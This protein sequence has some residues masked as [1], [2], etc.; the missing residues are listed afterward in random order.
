MSTKYELVPMNKYVV[1]KPQAEDEK[2]GLL[3]RPASA[4]EKQH[5]T[6]T[7]IAFDECD[8]AKKLRVGAQVIYDSI[9]SVEHR[10][11]NEMFTTVKVL[12]IIAVVRPV[13]FPDTIAV[14]PN[15]V[16]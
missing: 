2:V 15:G 10:V 9:G 6:G 3:Y 11:G 13:Q 8:E 16:V 14:D 12:N 7:I 5:K 1:I 4:L